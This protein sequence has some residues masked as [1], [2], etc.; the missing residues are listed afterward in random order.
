MDERVFDDWL[1]AYGRAW[2]ERDPD[3]AAALFTD[4][5]DYYETPFDEPFSG[6]EAI[7]AYWADVPKYQNAIRFRYEI[8]AVTGDTG[9]ARWWC[10]F[11]RLPSGR[12]VSLDGIFV[13]T[14]AG[15]SD[16]CAVFEE[17][18][19]RQEEEAVGD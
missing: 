19:H 14:M 17:W 9:I 4:E 8:L 1:K 15:G 7:F 13:V 11:N 18:W 3:A 10:D 16:Q 2:E 12:S 5:A 6:R